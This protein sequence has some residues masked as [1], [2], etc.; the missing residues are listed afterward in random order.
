MMR[1]TSTMEYN[2]DSLHKQVNIA[3]EI[4]VDIDFI[5][6]DNC[7]KLYSRIGEEKS[8]CWYLVDERE[9]RIMKLVKLPRS[10]INRIL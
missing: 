10:K 2:L 5:G 1:G 8:F 4:V 7:R 6:I 3:Q 9:E